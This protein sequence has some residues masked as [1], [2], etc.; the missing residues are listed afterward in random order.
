MVSAVI[1]MMVCVLVSNAD[2]SGECTERY[3]EAVGQYYFLHSSILP[4]IKSRFGGGELDPIPAA[5]G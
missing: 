5:I 2:C 1:C 4:L 3:F